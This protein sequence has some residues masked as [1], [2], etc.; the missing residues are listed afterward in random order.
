MSCRCRQADER[1][2]EVVR[3]GAPKTSGAGRS[4]RAP[5][6]AALVGGRLRRDLLRVGGG[7]GGLSSSSTILG[8]EQILLLA[9]RELDR[10]AVEAALGGAAVMI[11]A[12]VSSSG[13][14]SSGL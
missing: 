9:E 5:P 14:P 2:L 7:G 4:A 13:T 12:G 3:G 1:E 6:C 10:V 11:A 8:R